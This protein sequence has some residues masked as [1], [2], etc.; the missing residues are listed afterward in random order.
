MRGGGSVREEEEAAAMTRG[1][2]GRCAWS[3]LC[4]FPKQSTKTSPLYKNVVEEEEN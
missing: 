4:P 1:A 2:A 3:G